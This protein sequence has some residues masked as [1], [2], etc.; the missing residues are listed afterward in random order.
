[1]S[2]AN[3]AYLIGC[4]LVLQNGLLS[5]ASTQLP[6]LFGLTSSNVFQR[7]GH[8]VLSS[9]THVFLAVGPAAIALRDVGRIFQVARR[10]LSLSWPLQ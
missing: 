9:E 1:L 4:D 8:V 3:V 7:F 6:K 2:A 10:Y 5:I